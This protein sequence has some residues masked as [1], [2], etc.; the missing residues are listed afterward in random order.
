MRIL[1]HSPYFAPELISIGKYNAEMAQWL[2]QQGHQV[3]VVT[4]APHYPAWRVGAGYSAARYSRETIE[5]VDVWRCPAW[6]PRRPGGLVRMLYTLSHMLSSLPVLLW[7]ALWRPQIVMAVEPPLLS[8]LPAWLAAR[9]CGARTWLHVQDL[10]VD[11][12]FD[13]GILQGQRARRWALALEAALLRRADG[14]STISGRMADRLR[15]KGVPA[16]RLLIVPNWADELPPDPPGIDFRQMLDIPAGQRIAMYA[17]NMAGKQGLET[18][19]EAARL[20]RHRGDIFFVLAGDGPAREALH[21]LAQGLQQIRF[22]PLQPLS[23]LGAMLR[24]ADVHLLPQRAAAADLVMPSKLGGMFAS[25]RATVA[26]VRPDTEVAAAV[27]GCGVVVPPE[28]APAFAAAVE[29]LCDDPQ[30]AARL[31]ANAQARVRAELGKDAVLSRLQAGFTRLCDGQ[32]AAAH[33]G[34][35]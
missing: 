8:F 20:L 23:H 24:A 1:L 27:L 6:I 19:V 35:H 15:S 34:R 11:A 10:E 14:V 12:A 3:R 22:L 29:A 7:Q 28:D 4:A 13:L 16:Q 17:G 32:P 30:R 26:G 5:G 33:N 31:G 25:G 9:C 21:T 2:V 18:I